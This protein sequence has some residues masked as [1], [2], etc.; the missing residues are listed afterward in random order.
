MP[1]AS[2]YWGP[3]S[4]RKAKSIALVASQKALFASWTAIAI[5]VSAMA[6]TF[7]AWS[8]VNVLLHSQ[9][10][11]LAMP[12]NSA[13]VETVMVTGSEPF[14]ASAIE[15]QKNWKNRETVCVLLLSEV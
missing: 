6:H 10:V 12:M 3:S 5:P 14:G 7:T 2:Q 9:R 1:F 11:V 15:A 4:S 8:P 13:K